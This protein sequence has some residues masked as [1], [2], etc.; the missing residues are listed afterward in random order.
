[1]AFGDGARL[2]ADVGS[3]YVRFA[4]ETSRGEF[5]RQ[6]MVRCADYPDFGGALRGYMNT[7][8]DVGVRHAAVAVA[9][10]V[11]GDMVRM[12]N[13][14]WQFSIEQTR[15]DVGLDTLVVVNDFTALA[16][17]LPH[18]PAG[19][20]RKVGGGTARDRSVIGLLGAG[21][22]LGVS[23]LIPADDGWVS[24]G[25]E[26]GHV[27]FS[28]TDARET[29]ILD[30]AR[31]QY[32]HVSNERLL[33]A[34]GIELIY[35]AL[36]QLSKK[37]IE[38]LTA[39]EITARGLAGKSK[40][41]A[42]TLEVFCGM[43]GTAAANLA[44]TLGA[45][46]GIYVGGSIVPRLGTYFA[47]SPFRARFE[48][49]GRFSNYVAQIPTFVITAE[50]ATFI[51][52]AAVLDAQLKRRGQG[53]SVLDRIHQAQTELSPAERRVADLVLS[54]PRS[55]LNDPISEIARAAEVS[56]PTVVRFCRSLGC[57]GLS[58]FKLRL[59][60]SLTGTIPVTHTKV[61]G[62]DSA[63]ELG[64]KV[65]GN[66]ASAILQTRDM[67]N[68]AAIERAID[69][70]MAAR[71]IEFFAYGNYGIVAEDAQYKFLRFGLPANARIDPRL[72]VLAAEQLSPEDV[73]VVV[74]STGRIAELNAAIEAAIS[75]GA[76]VIA[77]TAS[78]SPLAKRATITIAVDHAEDVATQVPM[79]SRVLYLLV[80]DILAVGVAMRTGKSGADGVSLEA[81]DD[82]AERAKRLAGM[83]SHS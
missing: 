34:S 36:G 79:I 12:T 61:T 7:V 8:A 69:A 50:N 3:M 41:C 42:E 2:L 66:T 6:S 45:F 73:V 67:L 19:E 11:E 65:L 20:L 24:L 31:G 77:I 44:V 53:S 54:R 40:E 1:M 78:Q 47:S 23:A 38:P 57:E 39:P 80:I 51:G 76:K 58:D 49:K 22:G 13:Y 52:L 17:G 75:K 82:P 33:S 18:L 10:P 48:A 15:Q 60:S 70:L 5:T 25:T 59:A 71:R 81:Q 29:A 21:T 63:V 26:G 4:L 14:H 32:A 74:S 55:I 68:R 16:A 35:R 27:S 62:E 56:Q 43:M 28:P 72:Q 9:N 83:V 30:V 64:D 46:G 37:T